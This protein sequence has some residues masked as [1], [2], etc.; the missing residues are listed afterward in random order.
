MMM[1]CW[2]C[3]GR[4]PNSSS[5][6]ITVFSSEEAIYY[7][8]DLSSGKVHFHKYC[9][10]QYSGIEWMTHRSNN[11]CYVCEKNISGNLRSLDDL[12]K[13]YIFIVK[14]PLLD[15]AGSNNSKMTLSITG[16]RLLTLDEAEAILRE[17]QKLVEM[18]CSVFFYQMISILLENQKMVA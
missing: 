2:L 13:Q 12:I 15:I 9:F 10:S 3:G 6:I 18:M 16:N 4:L 8:D 5:S 14:C 1:S 17:C 7:R 11:D